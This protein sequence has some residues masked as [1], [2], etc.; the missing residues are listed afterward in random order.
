MPYIIL[1]LKSGKK[2]MKPWTKQNTTYP[3][4][5]ISEFKTRLQGGKAK[6]SAEVA[7]LVLALVLEEGGNVPS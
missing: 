5:S 6:K 1:I 4:H 2:N 3:A 7:A